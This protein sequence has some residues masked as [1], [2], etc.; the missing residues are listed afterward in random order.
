MRLVFG[1][2]LIAG[3][4]LAGSA[5]YLARGY[6]SQIETELEARRAEEAQRVEV[7][8][9]Y[10]AAVPLRYGH[11]LT[12]ED[13]GLIRFPKNSLPP[14]A[15]LGINPETGEPSTALFPNNN[16]APRTVLRAIEPNEPILAVKVTEPGANAGVQT[17]LTPGMRAFAINVDATSSVSGFV[18]PGDRVDVYWNGNINGVSQTRL[19]DT[20][21]RIIAIGQ[22][23][24]QDDRTPQVAGT[25]TVEVSPE[26][27]ASLTQAQS[28]GRLTLSLLGVGDVSNSENS[29]QINNS[30][31]FG[32]VEQ[33][34]KPEVAPT[35]NCGVVVRQGTEGE[36][37]VREV[38]CRD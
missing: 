37:S 4:A 9:I 25:V 2:V 10:V 35:R 5:V 26:Q 15:F 23:V 27:V 28:S 6:F 12:P 7:V 22:S 38:D 1:L 30:E 14:G 13:V 21:I 11:R 18:R 31:L 36:G 24:D 16:S 3:L 32:I 20:N 29:I 17:M 8:E 34:P 19:I 33:A